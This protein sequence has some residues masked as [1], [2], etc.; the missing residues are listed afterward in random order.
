MRSSLLFVCVL[1]L[2]TTGCFRTRADLA[3]EKEEKE[4][5]S[6]LRENIVEYNRG[7]ERLQA[8]VGRLQGK[9]EEMD[10]SR[11]K[12]M[13]SSREGAEK[14]QADLAARVASLQ[15]AQAALFEEIKQLKEDN[16]QLLK[17]VSDRARPAPAAPVKKNANNYASALSAFKAKNYE[18]AAE[19]FRAYLEA[20][21]KGKS[22]LD[23]Q[24]Y[25]GESLYRQKDF[26]EAIVA[27]G[28][29]HE[30]S[31]TS[32]LGRK[33]TLRIAE[34]FDALGKKKDAKAF[35]E[36]LVQSSPDSA[37]AK[38]ARKYLR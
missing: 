11:R 23:A 13:S 2:L 30:R 8:D 26:S 7:L 34:S 31:A 15:Q 5:Q 25:L 37:E 16:V 38:K 10:H 1:T 32:E 9:V 22:S 29:V 18:A 14:S 19:G 17:L 12:E 24:Y 28:A 36:I 20:S 35:A 21:P 3:R 6:D 27:Y 33:S 4:V